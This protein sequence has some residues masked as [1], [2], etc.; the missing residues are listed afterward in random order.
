MNPI[1]RT[2]TSID[3]VKEQYLRQDKKQD[4][5]KKDGTTFAEV[6]Q[7]KQLEIDTDEIKFSKHA[8]VR[9]ESRNIT[10]TN[11]QSAR[12]ENGMKKAEEKGIQDSLVIVDSHAFIVNIPNKTVVTAM[13]SKETLEHVFTN[14]DGAVII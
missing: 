6:L 4:I 14:I 7:N 12:L 3:Q 5:V 11:D 9:M 2:F 13:D 8:I 1:N 10:L